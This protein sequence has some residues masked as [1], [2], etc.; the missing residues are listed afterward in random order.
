M[1]DVMVPHT[2]I[3][4]GDH[5][6]SSFGISGG[7]S[8]CNQNIFPTNELPLQVAQAMGPPQFQASN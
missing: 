5:I 7:I 8:S 2:L 3:S 6:I 4:T 1:H